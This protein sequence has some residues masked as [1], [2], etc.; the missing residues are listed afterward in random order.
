ML[1]SCFGAGIS[2][3]GTG[4][5]VALVLGSPWHWCWGL[6]GIGVGGR[7]GSGA[8]CLRGI[9]AGVS[10]ALVLDSSYGNGFSMVLVPGSA[11]HWCWD[12][13]VGVFKVLVLA[14]PR[15]WCWGLASVL[16]SPC[17]WCWGLAVMLVLRISYES[18]QGV[19]TGVAVTMVWLSGP[20]MGMGSPWYGLLESI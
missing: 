13:A 10:M 3:C 9:N 7:H 11:W 8:W 12:L 6:R 2:G 20:A 17:C 1:L 19:G 15:H 16:G 4:V 14:S 18:Q 5:S